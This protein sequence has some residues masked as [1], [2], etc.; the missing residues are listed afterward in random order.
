MI[1]LIN[2]KGGVGKTTTAVNLAAGLVRYSYQVLLIDLDSQGSASFSLG[3]ERDNLVPGIANVLLQGQSI[4]EVIR[5][6]EIANLDLLTGSIDLASADILLTNAES[7]ENRLQQALEPVLHRYDFILIDCP[8]SLG[9]LT[10]NALV[11]SSHYIAPVTPHYLA[12][13]GLV[14]LLQAVD[15]IQAGIGR[16]AKLLGLVLTMVDRRTRVAGEI[17]ELIQ[18]HY[19]NRVFAT[20][21]PVNTKVSEAP[22]WGQS[23]F[24]YAPASTGA[25]AYR[26]LTEELLQRVAKY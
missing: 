6:T 16:G 18:H 5:K 2:S 8:P 17:A 19:G 15:L 14:N 3:M 21:V 13:E 26:K 1:S 20:E 7:R 12:L 22:S 23:I 4:A 25:E 10:V 9:L 24:E 11:A